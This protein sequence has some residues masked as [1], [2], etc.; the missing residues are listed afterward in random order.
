[1]LLPGVVPKAKSKIHT[2]FFL[3]V[4]SNR[5]VAWKTILI[6]ELGFFPVVNSQYIHTKMFPLPQFSFYDP[7]HV[8]SVTFSPFINVI[9]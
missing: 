7:S 9:N 3:K 6:I 4:M 8:I 2:S 1:V 5:T